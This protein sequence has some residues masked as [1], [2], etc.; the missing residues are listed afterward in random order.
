MDHQSDFDPLVKSFQIEDA[1]NRVI[2]GSPTLNHV[3][4][5]RR[6]VSVDRDT[7]HQVRMLDSRIKFGER[8]ILEGSSIGKQMYCRVRETSFG[9][10]QQFDQS[11]PVKGWF[12]ACQDQF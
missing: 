3:V 9:M 10:I 2:E 12:A 4:M 5:C 11:E 6:V 7:Y 8:E 1:P